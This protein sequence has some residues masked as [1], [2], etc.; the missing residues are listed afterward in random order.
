MFACNQCE[1][2]LSLYPHQASA[3]AATMQAYG[4]IWEWRGSIFKR[5]NVFQWIQSDA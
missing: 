4:D 3:S 5:H 2:G 1:R